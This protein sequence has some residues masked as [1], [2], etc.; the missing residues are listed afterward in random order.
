MLRYI[1]YYNICG[2]FKKNLSDCSW[3][4]SL[5]YFSVMDNQPTYIW[6]NCTNADIQAIWKIKQ[7]RGI[8]F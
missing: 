4:I 6:M 7:L 3:R 2:R 8:N 5:V 1:N